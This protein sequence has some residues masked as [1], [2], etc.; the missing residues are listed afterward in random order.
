[1]SLDFCAL[2]VLF[3]VLLKDD[4]A[5]QQRYT[6]A[7]FWAVSLTPL[8]GPALYLTLRPNTISPATSAPEAQSA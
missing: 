4:M 7:L 2:C 3:P 5:R 1:M 6:P 8:L